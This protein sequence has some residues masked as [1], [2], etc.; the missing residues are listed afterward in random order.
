MM[1]DEMLKQ[2][3]QDLPN[4]SKKELYSI[5]LTALNQCLL[6]KREIDGYEKMLDV[7]TDKVISSVSQLM[8]EY[9]AERARDMIKMILNEKTMGVKNE[10]IR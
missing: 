7:T 8:N 5:A 1:P 9:R 6:S 2:M 4:K 3:I 10:K